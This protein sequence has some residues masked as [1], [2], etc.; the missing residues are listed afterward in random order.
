M[1]NFTFFFA[2][3]QTPLLDLN[4]FFYPSF[5]RANQYVSNVISSRTK[6]IIL[7]QYENERRGKVSLVFLLMTNRKSQ[8]KKIL[9][10]YTQ[11]ISKYSTNNCTFFRMKLTFH[12]RYI[13]RRR[14][15]HI[16]MSDGYI[17]KRRYP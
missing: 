14:N 11:L 3:L 16:R 2:R 13:T 17:N 12:Q 6:L 4:T 9:L 7:Y 5:C 15:E 1:N 8:F 10:Y